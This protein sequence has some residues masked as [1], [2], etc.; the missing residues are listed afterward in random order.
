MDSTVDPA[1]VAKYRDMMRNGRSLPSMAIVAP[2]APATAKRRK[3]NPQSAERFKT[4][5]EF[6]D[7]SAKSVSTTAQAAWWILFRETKPSGLASVSLSQLAESIGMK[8]RTAIYAIQE[9]E[10]GGLL[11]VVKR[12]NAKTGSSIYRIHGTAKQGN[13]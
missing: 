4:M 7:L 2:P 3:K 12:G 1:E 5:N 13:R 6:A 10:R 9:L 11:S 8:R